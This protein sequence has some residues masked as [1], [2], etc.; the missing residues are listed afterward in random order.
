[1]LDKINN[2]INSITDIK[3]ELKKIKDKVNKGIESTFVF[4]LPDDP[5][6][7]QALI[8]NIKAE[9]DDALNFVWNKICR[10]NKI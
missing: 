4:K 2:K 1:M 10:E 7:M 6:L 5:K 3:I 8:N 9:I